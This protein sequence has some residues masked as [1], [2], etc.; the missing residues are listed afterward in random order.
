M[1][2]FWLLINGPGSVNRPSY[3]CR[4]GLC[5]KS[6]GVKHF[7]IMFCQ[8]LWNLALDYHGHVVAPLVTLQEPGHPGQTARVLDSQGMSIAECKC[9]MLREAEW[10]WP[11]CRWTWR[12]S[13]Q[14]WWKFWGATQGVTWGDSGNCWTA[15][16]AF[17]RLAG[18]INRR[19]CGDMSFGVRDASWI[20][21]V[22]MSCACCTRLQPWHFEWYLSWFRGMN[23]V[24]SSLAVEMEERWGYLWNPMGRWSPMTS[25]TPVLWSPLRFRAQDR[26]NAAQ[27]DEP[28]DTEGGCTGKRGAQPW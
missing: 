10:L 26:C 28:G 13:T 15:V 19:N 27:Q 12:C 17:Q 6:S 5:L 1:L 24:H 9:S 18:A 7:D 22:G 11:L 25:M 2:N 21:W 8:P 3:V 16:L 23:A 4:L 20:Q 14:A